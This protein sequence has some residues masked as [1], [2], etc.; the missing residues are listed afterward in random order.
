MSTNKKIGRPLSG[1]EL[2][3]H[4]LKVRVSEN[5]FLK[6]QELSKDKGITVAEF[7]RIAISRQIKNDEN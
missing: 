5:T 4:D 7:T 3:S 1:D 6:M 2:L